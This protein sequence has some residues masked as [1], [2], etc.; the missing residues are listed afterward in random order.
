MGAKLL[1]GQ[2]NKLKRKH[3]STANSLKR[4]LHG[5]A[6]MLYG[7]NKTD[8]RQS[9]GQCFIAYSKRVLVSK[10]NERDG[11]RRKELPGLK[12][13]SNCYS[14]NLMISRISVQICPA[15]NSICR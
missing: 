5:Q 6:V 9:L 4:H 11:G 7:S 10:V 13:Q 1:S 2:L 14:S 12:I 15:R 3:K 8:L